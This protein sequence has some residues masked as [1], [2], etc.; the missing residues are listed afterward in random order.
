MLRPIATPLTMGGFDPTVMD[1]ISAIFNQQGFAP[2]MA[3]ALQQGAGTPTAQTGPLRP[4][5]PVGV[6]LMS[7]DMELGA[8][9]TV[10]EVDG[11]RVYAFGHPFYGLGPVSFPMTRAYVHTLLPSFANSSKRPMRL[12]PPCRPFVTTCMPWVR[13]PCR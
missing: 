5:D 8:T 4:G 6:T 9:G 3:A 10:T 11:N 2:V 1:S 12:H 13:S 7:G